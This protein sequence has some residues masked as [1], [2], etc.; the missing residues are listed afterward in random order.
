MMHQDDGRVG[1][2][3]DKLGGSCSESIL[4]IPLLVIVVSS[5]GASCS[6]FVAFISGPYPSL[7]S[8][9]LQRAVLVYHFQELES[10]PLP[11][12]S[13]LRILLTAARCVRNSST[14]RT[15]RTYAIRPV[16]SIPSL[17]LAADLSPKAV[18]LPGTC[19]AHFLPVSDCT[20]TAY[21]WR[22]KLRSLFRYA[23]H[24][25]QVILREYRQSNDDTGIDDRL[26]IIRLPSLASAHHTVHTEPTP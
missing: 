1:D 10:A 26:G 23:I 20:Y 22:K 19:L 6:I 7:C 18:F 4:H 24:V 14:V 15:P 11:A 21:V 12:P 17:L 8:K 25:H 16:S 9:L 13:T 5:T 3:A 2:H